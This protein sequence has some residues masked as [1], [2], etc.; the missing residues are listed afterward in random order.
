[1]RYPRRAN[2]QYARSGRNVVAVVLSECS[3][4]RFINVIDQLGDGIKPLVIIGISTDEIFFGKGRFR[5]PLFDES[6]GLDGKLVGS[7]V[8]RE[9]PNE[10]SS[11]TRVTVCVSILVSERI[12]KIR[13]EVH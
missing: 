3:D 12:G 9:L 11:R 6:N 1:M 7:V 4:G 13:S 2:I 10:N 8:S 5:W